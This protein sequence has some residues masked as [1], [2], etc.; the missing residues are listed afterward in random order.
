MFGKD[1]TSEWAQR[2]EQVREVNRLLRVI[3]ATARNHAEYVAQH[4]QL[5]GTAVWVLGEL[6]RQPGLRPRD[7]ARQLALHVQVVSEAVADLETRNLVHA[8]MG[9]T[10]RAR[11]FLTEAGVNLI[12]AA[13]GPAQGVLTAALHDLDDQAL[14]ALTKTLGS[15]VDGLPAAERSAAILPLADF[16]STERASQA[17]RGLKDEPQA[18]AVAVPVPGVTQEMHA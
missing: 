9:E 15:L 11:Y 18:M 3:V 6:R 8:V 7:L 13:P 10:T 2:Q 16:V 1:I 12:D 4:C 17:R 14:G 5:D